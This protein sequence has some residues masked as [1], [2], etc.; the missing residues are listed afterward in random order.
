MYRDQSSCQSIWLQS[1]RSR[2]RFPAL[3]AFLSSIGSEMGSTQPREY[4]LGAT[5]KKKYR[6]WSINLRLTVVGVPTRWPR[7]TPLSTK[8]GIKIGRP[9]AVAQSLD[10]ACG[11]KA[12]K[13]ICIKCYGVYS[14]KHHDFILFSRN[15][16]DMGPSYWQHYQ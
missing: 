15:K 8:V 7:D 11:L 6:L 14:M 13:F 10:F 16:E 1:Q 3:P 2:V 12:T 9:V 5:W 4:K